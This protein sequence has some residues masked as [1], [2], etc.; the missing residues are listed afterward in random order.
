MTIDWTKPVETTEGW[1]AR[2]LATDLHSSYPVVAAIRNRNGVETVDAYTADGR[3]LYASDPV[4]RNVLPKPV[5]VEQFISFHPRPCHAAP[6]APS[7]G[8]CYPS[9]EY[10]EA[11]GLPGRHDSDLFR[12]LIK[13]VI[14]DGIVTSADLV[15]PA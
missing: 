15:Q 8:V 14:T 6:L 12:A 11:G 10:A 2:V 5:V 7:V 9:I 13:V 1:S 3:R 4:L